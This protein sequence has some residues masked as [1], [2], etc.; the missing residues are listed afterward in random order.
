MV[1][2]P[3]KKMENESNDWSDLT[4]H[5]FIITFEFENSSSKQI[6]LSKESYQQLEDEITQASGNWWTIK[7]ELVNLS[8]VMSIKIVDLTEQR[9]LN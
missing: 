1:A 6:M 4:M 8:K 3:V 5:D 2:R 7:G 9:G